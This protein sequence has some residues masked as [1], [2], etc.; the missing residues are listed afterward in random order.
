MPIEYQHADLV[1]GKIVAVSNTGPLLSAF[2]SSRTDLFWRYFSVVHIPESVLKE[3][4]AHG[5]GDFA[6][7]FIAEGLLVVETIRPEESAKVEQLA[8]Q[9]A[10][11]GKT[12]A[13]PAT[14]PRQ[15]P[16]C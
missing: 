2:Q 11:S 8:R 16:S 10:A 4:Q 12:K 1:A 7:N 5:A 14:K 9:I 13:M 3:M 15:K 6:R